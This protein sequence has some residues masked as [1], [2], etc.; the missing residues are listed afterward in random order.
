VGVDRKGRIKKFMMDYVRWM[1]KLD[2]C[3]PRYV[4]T[5]E[6]GMDKLKIGWGTRAKRF[7]KRIRN[8]EGSIVEQC[9]REKEEGG[10]KKIYGLEKKRGYLRN[11]WV[12][13]ER[14]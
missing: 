13:E 3:T 9:R 14:E 5:R 2:Y 12:E 1:F 7:E 6:I 10:W 11:G 8:R 4:I